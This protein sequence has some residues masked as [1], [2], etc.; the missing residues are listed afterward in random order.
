MTFFWLKKTIHLEPVI[1]KRNNWEI[2]SSLAIQ[3]NTH[4]PTYPKHVEENYKNSQK[5]PHVFIKYETRILIVMND[6][7]FLWT[8]QIFFKENK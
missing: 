5:Y 8:Y 3:N 4:G 2:V 7:S 6:F 1:I